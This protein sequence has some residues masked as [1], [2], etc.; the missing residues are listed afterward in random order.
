MERVAFLLESTGERLA[1]MLNPDSLIIRRLAG[2][3]N[4]DSATGPLTGARLK[5]DPLLYT[6]G[7]MT[8]LILDLLFDITLAGSSVMA[9]D[10]RQLTRPLMELAEGETGGDGYSRPPLVR[11]V[12]GKQWNVLGVVTAA[13]ERLEYF[14]SDGA[15][16]RS[17]LRMRLVRVTDPSATA[18]AVPPSAEVPELPEELEI[19]PEQ[20]EVH[21]VLGG[22]PSGKTEEEV[23]AE[24]PEPGG[25]T[26]RLDEIAHRLY[27]DCRFWRLIANFNNIDNPL[28]LGAG[29]LLRIPPRSAVEG[30][31]A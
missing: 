21:E 24:E 31:S 5:D 27:G 18:S 29:H 26:E 23:E 3:R 22:G 10:V 1:C 11:F 19:P 4:R 25:S 30:T 2:V 20:V 6:G 15:P 28:E 12:W 14:T 8:E 13:A 9:E 7:G 16:R 17:W